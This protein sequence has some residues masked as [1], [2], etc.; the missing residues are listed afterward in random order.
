MRRLFPFAALAVAACATAPQQAPAPEPS[1]PAPVEVRS[2]L[3]GQTEAEL[4]GRF[5]PA[6]FRVRE[7]AGLKLQWQNASCVLDAYLY[8][9]EHGS[10]AAMVLHVD[11]RRPLSGETVPVEG[12]VSSLTR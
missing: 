6:S 12:C 4:T 3:S 8:P 2:N 1:R 9:P 10:G 5:G 11:T 7:G